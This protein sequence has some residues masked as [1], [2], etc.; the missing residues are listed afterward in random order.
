MKHIKR[1]YINITWK[2][3][4]EFIDTLLSFLYIYFIRVVI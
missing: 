3:L 1:L 4:L 2:L